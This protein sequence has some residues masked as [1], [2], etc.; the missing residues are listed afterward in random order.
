MLKNIA[1]GLSYI[2][3]KTA[4]FALFSNCDIRY[5]AKLQSHPRVLIIF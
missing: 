3:A 4:H 2:L 1:I 5:L